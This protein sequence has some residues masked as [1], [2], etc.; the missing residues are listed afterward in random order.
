MTTTKTTTIDDVIDALY[1]AG[2]TRVAPRVHDTWY[3]SVEDRGDGTVYVCDPQ[4]GFLAHADALIASL[5]SVSPDGSEG[6]DEAELDAWHGRLWDA[7]NSVEIVD[8]ES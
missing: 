6:E 7:F 3:W 8:D 2:C 5:S 4:E 1:R